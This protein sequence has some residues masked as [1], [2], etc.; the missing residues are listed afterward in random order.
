MTDDEL[1]ELGLISLTQEHY[2]TLQHELVSRLRRINEMYVTI[3]SRVPTPTCP[4]L[5]K[6]LFKA[7]PVGPSDDITGDGLFDLFLDTAHDVAQARLGCYLKSPIGA[8]VRRRLAADLKIS[9]HRLLLSLVQDVAKST[10]YADANSSKIISQM[11]VFGAEKSA[12]VKALELQFLFGKYCSIFQDEGI[13][14]RDVEL[15]AR[16]FALLIP[17]ADQRIV[18]DQLD[19]EGGGFIFFVYF[20][21]WMRSDNP[22]LYQEFSAQL[23]QD[24]LRTLQAATRSKYY[25]HAADVLLARFRTVQRMEV[26]VREGI[27]YTD[28]FRAD[29]YMHT[30]HVFYRRCEGGAVNEDL[31]ARKY[32]ILS[33]STRGGGHIM[34]DEESLDDTGTLGHNSLLG[35]PPPAHSVS[36]L[37]PAAPIL[38]ASPSGSPGRGDAKHPQAESVAGAGA[39]AGVGTAEEDEGA[40]FGGEDDGSLEEVNAAAA[41]LLPTKEFVKPTIQG[42]VYD[43]LTKWYTLRWREEESE[44]R[45]IYSVVEQRAELQYWQNIVTPVGWYNLWTER[46][47]LQQLDTMID[48]TGYCMVHRMQSPPRTAGGVLGATIQ[49]ALSFYGA[50]SVSSLASGSFQQYSATVSHVLSVKDQDSTQLYDNASI[51]SHTHSFA[52]DDDDHP[53]AYLDPGS[54]QGKGAGGGYEQSIGSGSPSGPLMPM[55]PEPGSVTGTAIDRGGEESESDGLI[56]GN[57]NTNSILLEEEAVALTAHGRAL[58]TAVLE[59]AVSVFDT[60]CTGDLDEGEVRVLLRCLHCALSEKAFRH[61]FA[62]NDDVIRGVSVRKLINHLSERVHWDHKEVWKKATGQRQAGIGIAKR[63]NIGCAA[64]IL[65]SLQRQ[66]AHKRALQ[67]VKLSK[68]GRIVMLRES[69]AGSSDQ[70]LLVRSQLFAMRQVSMFL[71]TTQGTIK[72][73]HALQDLLFSWQRDVLNVAPHHAVATSG[74]YYVNYA[75]ALHQEGD[76]VLATEIPHVVKFLVTKLRLVPTRRVEEL[77]LMFTGLRG[78]ASDIRCLNH[79]E[80][81]G[82][83]APLFLQPKAVEPNTFLRRLGLKRRLR[84]D[85]KLR[86]YSCARQQAVKIAMDFPVIEV[87]ET[88]YRCSVLGLRLFI[89]RSLP[90]ALFSTKGKAKA[91]AKEVATP[92]K[93]AKDISGPTE[94]AA[95]AADSPDDVSTIAGSVVTTTV[96]LPADCVPKEAVALHLLSLGYSISDLS[97]PC[98]A[99]LL[100]VDHLQGHLQLV[101]VSLAAAV[102]AARKG[103]SK[104]G[105][106]FEAARRLRRKL[107][108]YWRLHLEFKQVVRALTQYSAV[109]DKKGGEFLK[110]ILTGVSHCME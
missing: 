16:E 98:L 82:L 3:Y 29:L 11:N 69:H 93:P 64:G 102:D 58:Y 21:R 100:D 33:Q 72:L 87:S 35:L 96:M 44:N 70:T 38:S 37:A 26:T 83:L 75:Y 31:N 62:D 6:L 39:G 65:V 53:F 88:N 60:D 12:A 76:G 15:V 19:P 17:E 18:V 99:D 32:H 13:D 54:V 68:I 67:S 46:K 95:A 89:Q 55:S 109:V 85:A 48:A 10:K 107:L 80:F 81:T 86:M 91:P 8:M 74:V 50:S 47:L 77:A 40:G 61:T 1:Q 2:L 5:R 106:Y 52:G 63:A 49:E 27:L 7:V 22:A 9:K 59:M 34:L 36:G 97:H 105:T 110:E 43:N 79:A 66:L 51:S 20:L 30:L 108:K 23:R 78:S 92:V 71:H 57:T 84:R 42:G 41:P 56:Q 90:V 14:V 103:I 45:V 94:A 4:T 104:T 25:F 73:H 101:P 24:L 28:D